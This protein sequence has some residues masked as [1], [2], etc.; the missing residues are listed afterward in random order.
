MKIVSTETFI[1][2]LGCMVYPITFIKFIL[3]RRRI[4]HYFTS[5]AYPKS[6][7]RIPLYNLD[8]GRCRACKSKV[9][10][11]MLCRQHTSIERVLSAKTVAFD[12]D[13]QL[14]FYKNEIFRMIGKKLVIVYCPHTKLIRGD[15]TDEKVRKVTPITIEDFTLESLPEY[16]NVQKFIMNPLMLSNMRCWFNDVFSIV[17][18][19]Q[20]DKD[21]DFCLIA[22]R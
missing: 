4:L 7:S 6:K 17:T 14:F 12:M 8:F 3:N 20:E 9:E 10:Q 18:I 1:E 16:E 15:I 11:R 19:P 22:N 5:A 2:R 13:S 21:S